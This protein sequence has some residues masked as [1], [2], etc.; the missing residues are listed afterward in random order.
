MGIKEELI[1]ELIKA[2]NKFFDDFEKMEDITY[3]R[4][5]WELDYMVYPYIGSFL[6]SGD[7]S[8]DDAVEIFKL[9]EN[10]LKELKLKLD[11]V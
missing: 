3:E 2:I 8:K 1:E 5:R 4:V 9:C 10:R 7:I 11:G 6:A